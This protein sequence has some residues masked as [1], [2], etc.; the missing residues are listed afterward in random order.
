MRISKTWSVGIFK[1]EKKFD[2]IHG[3]R[4][5][6]LVHTI[7]GRSSG[8][9]DYIKIIRKI[10]KTYPISYLQIV[11]A[12]TNPT[13]MMIK[14]WKKAKMSGFIFFDLNAGSFEHMNLQWGIVDVY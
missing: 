12:E 13:N 7:S 11:S 14:G 6:N 10:F 8:P 2:I 9:G 3:A 4:P 5:G 1:E